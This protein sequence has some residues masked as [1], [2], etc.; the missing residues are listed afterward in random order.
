MYNL[1]A[2]TKP[3]TLDEIP[4]NTCGL[5]TSVLVTTTT[6]STVILGAVLAVLQAA[7]IIYNSKSC[8]LMVYS[9]GS[10]VG[11]KSSSEGNRGSEVDSGDCCLES[12]NS[13]LDLLPNSYSKLDVFLYKS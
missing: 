10:V 5:A 3:K 7:P 13:V 1:H 8:Q 12:T 11:I 4:L 6:S 9:S 2:V